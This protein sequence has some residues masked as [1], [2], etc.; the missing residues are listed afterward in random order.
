MLLYNIQL[1]PDID[2]LIQEIETCD[3]HFLHENIKNQL[4]GY[5]K[6]NW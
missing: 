3:I 1:Y 5:G 2:V 4:P 6:N